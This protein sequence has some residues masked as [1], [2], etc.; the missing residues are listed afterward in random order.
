[1]A[2]LKGTYVLRRSRAAL[3]LAGILVTVSGCGH[4]S[5]RRS[6]GPVRA[7]VALF[8][9]PRVQSAFRNEGISFH[10]T[11]HLPSFSEYISNEGFPKSWA[12]LQIFKT[13][14]RARMTAP[15]YVIDGQPVYAVRFKNVLVWIDPRDSN[16]VRARIY[17]ALR[18]LQAG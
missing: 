12:I 6:G 16:R 17:S 11:V 18:R 13:V 5:A 14:A 10:R 15:V 2:T 3:V 8:S 9:V 4:V 7:P 1:M